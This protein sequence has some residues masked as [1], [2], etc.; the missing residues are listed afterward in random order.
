MS[1]MQK[2]IKKSVSLSGKGLH[3][4]QEVTLTFH[5]API[6]HGFMFQR[7]DLEGKPKITPNVDNVVDTS[8]G[9]TL[10]ENGAQ[11]HTIEHVLASLVGLGLDNI[12]ME[13]TGPEAPILDGSSI[14]YVEAL[15]GVGFEEQ[16]AEKNYYVIK[17]RT[18]FRDEE[19][20]I[21]LVAYPDDNFSIDVMVDYNSKVLGNQYASY[22]PTHD[23][24]KE[25][26]PSRTFVFFHELEYLLKHNLIKGGDLQNAIVIM[27][28]EVSQ[29]ELDRM[30]DLF[31]KPHV[32]V[33]EGI[34]NN[35][36]LRFSNEPARHKLLDILGDLT[37]IGRPI[38]GKI[39][40]SRPGHY[41]NTELAKIIKESIKKEESRIAIPQYDPNKKAVYDIN[42]IKGLLPH[43]Y[44]FLLIDKVTELNETS[45]IG[46]KNVTMNENFF[47]GHFPNEP[48]MPGVLQV[49]AMAQVGGIL[50]LSQVEDPENYQ[51]LFL[52]IDK[53]KF[54]RKVIP[55]DT[56]I[57]RMEL[58]SPIRR[59]L[60]NMFG[61]A[62]V[63]EE[64]AMEGELM[65]QVSKIQ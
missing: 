48:I 15:K 51:T 50:A 21:E 61:Q 41:A 59:G 6:N 36:D 34:L 17:E 44:P 58:I 26:A 31:N 8:R 27:E 47:M 9:T 22:H 30:A 25:I 39:V 55:G 37:L 64:L 57:F 43:R 11:I 54:K 4:G 49:E 45:V 12:L 14:K 19:N 33:K 63:G 42:Q 5:P 20:N 29:D 62:F 13:F 2:T 32:K 23:F 3:T 53:V 7:V 38:K 46:I 1:E 10:E 52:K 35:V 60:V 16:N 65:A 24:E 56:I 18:V 40:A 28:N